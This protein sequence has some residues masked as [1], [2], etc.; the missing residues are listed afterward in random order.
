MAAAAAGHPVTRPVDSLE[1]RWMVPGLL[2][3]AMREWFAR[4]PA[5]TERREDTYL[6][7]G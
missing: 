3:T 2:R 6:Q 7:G 4:F 1:V 5:E